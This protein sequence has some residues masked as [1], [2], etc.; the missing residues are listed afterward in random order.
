MESHG[1]VEVRIW[2]LI[3]VV[4]L[5]DVEE[6]MDKMQ[7]RFNHSYKEQVRYRIW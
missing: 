7:K 2:P 1:F 3:C 5:W 6:V 4:E